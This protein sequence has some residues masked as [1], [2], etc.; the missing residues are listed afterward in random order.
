M[1]DQQAHEPCLLNLRYIA[2]WKAR[3]EHL[4]FAWFRLTNWEFE[5]TLCMIRTDGGDD[6]DAFR[7]SIGWSM[8]SRWSTE[9]IY[10]R[11][12]SNDAGRVDHRQPLV[13]HS[14]GFKG[15]HPKSKLQKVEDMWEG[16]NLIRGAAGGAQH[17]IQ[18]RKGGIKGHRLSKSF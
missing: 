11:R 4:Q 14:K 9:A 12:P 3:V 7:R 13:L 2:T 17:K 1:G 5:S 18:P 10:K 6:G 8:A 16:K 15:G